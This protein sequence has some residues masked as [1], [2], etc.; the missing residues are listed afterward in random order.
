MSNYRDIV[1]FGDLMQS[2]WSMLPD[3]LRSMLLAVAAA[4][5]IFGIIQLID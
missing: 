4:F 5:I 1:G 2:I 3:V